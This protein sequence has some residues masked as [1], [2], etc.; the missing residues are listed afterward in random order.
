[1]TIMLVLLK[2]KQQRIG[3]VALSIFMGSW[4]L[5]VCQSCLAAIDDSNNYNPVTE[6]LNVCH[7]PNTDD[8]N[9]EIS[10]TN[11]EHCLGACDCDVIASALNSDKNSKILLEKIKFS[12]GLFAYVEPKITLYNRAPP[13]YPISTTPEQAI[14]LP[15]QHYTVLLN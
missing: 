11:T 12:L 10:D 7:T 9:N 5:L 2:N 6:S 14:F 15:L 8:A 3:S 1:M 4:L 13:G